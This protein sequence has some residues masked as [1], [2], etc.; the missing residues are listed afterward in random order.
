MYKSIIFIE[1]QVS[2]DG[3]LFTSSDA[4]VNKAF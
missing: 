1:V 3:A 4:R 2:S